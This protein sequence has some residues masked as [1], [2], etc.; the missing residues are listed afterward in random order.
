ML[1]IWKPWFQ[2]ISYSHE[3]FD[4][5]YL[6]ARVMRRWSWIYP[7]SLGAFVSNMCSYQFKNLWIIIYFC[8]KTAKWY[9]GRVSET[10][11]LPNVSPVAG[12]LL[13]IWQTEVIFDIWW[14]H[15]GEKSRGLMNTQEWA[16]GRRGRVNIVHRK[17][18]SIMFEVLS[19]PLNPLGERSSNCQLVPSSLKSILC[20][21]TMGK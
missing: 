6:M 5:G 8:F 3:S 14:C 13:G 15:T 10:W 1:N 17:R 11:P 19:L 7:T 21:I 12:Q 9:G 20:L 18:Y 2:D 16:P 4:Y